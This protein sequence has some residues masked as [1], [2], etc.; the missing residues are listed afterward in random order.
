M[1]ATLGELGRGGD[2]DEAVG[3]LFRIV[4]TLKGSAL[5]VGCAPVGHVAHRLEDLLVDIRGGRLQLTPA[6][7]ESMFATVEAIRKML[8]IVPDDSINLTQVAERLM[9][10]LADLLSAPIEPTE[11]APAREP[12][13]AP[14]PPVR[15]EREAPR[16]GVRPVQRT[17]RVNLEHLDG[18]MDLVG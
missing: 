1:A 10:T 5:V 17:I 18:L 9:G 7:V 16:V 13:P 8:R 12:V 15:E 11:P 6:M 3:R 2:T 4:H 14:A